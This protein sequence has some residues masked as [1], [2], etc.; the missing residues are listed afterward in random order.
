[1]GFDTITFTYD[2]K[3][4]TSDSASESDSGTIEYALDVQLGRCE[5][6]ACH[7]MEPLLDTEII[8]SGTR[9]DN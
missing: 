4:D 2:G 8:P 9:W 6:D 7:K 1:M 3:M 5:L